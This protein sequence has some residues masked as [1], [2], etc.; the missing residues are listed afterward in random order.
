MK[1]VSNML[2]VNYFS[3][4]IVLFLC[5]ITPAEAQLRPA[6]RIQD[7]VCI[8]QNQEMREI[9]KILQHQEDRGLFDSF[10][11]LRVL[12]SPSTSV[13]ATSWSHIELSLAPLGEAS[14]E[15]RLHFHSVEESDG[16]IELKKDRV[17]ELLRHLKNILENS[18]AFGMESTYLQSC[19]DGFCRGNVFIENTIESWQAPRL[20]TGQYILSIENRET[21][22]TTKWDL[23][24]SIL[25]FHR[26]HQN[27]A[28]R[29][30]HR[31]FPNQCL[32]LGCSDRM[33]EFSPEDEG[34]REA[35]KSYEFFVRHFEILTRQALA[36]KAPS[37]ITIESVD[38]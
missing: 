33:E 16:P 27:S 26:R 34:F 12:F 18:H 8:D 10:R 21:G 31:L 14:F 28:A 2:K 13:E 5:A 38:P 9:K 3:L 36:E 29:S 19:S 23:S 25:E 35:F 37:Q 7:S 30:P 22:R 11:H 32:F 1:A 15:G 17:I 20:D 6:Y 4:G 24:K